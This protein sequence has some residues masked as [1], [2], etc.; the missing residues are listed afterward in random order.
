M[1]RPHSNSRSSSRKVL[2]GNSLNTNT[3][4]NNTPNCSKKLLTILKDYKKSIALYVLDEIKT[5]NLYPLEINLNSTYHNVLKGYLSILRDSTIYI[6]DTNIIDK[7]I[8]DL[9]QANKLNSIT[10][11]FS[12][13]AHSRV[14]SQ[15][16]KTL[17]RSR[18]V[19]S[20]RSRSLKTKQY[21]NT[22]KE[23]IM[24][25]LNKILCT[26]SMIF[27]YLSKDMINDVVLNIIQYNNIIKDTKDTITADTL[28]KRE[29]L[30]DDQ[31]YILR[32]YKLKYE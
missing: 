31:K 20:S 6:V 32:F 26:Q 14:R 27:K 29:A 21:T 24:R 30:L 2:S 25:K 9:P 28:A 19:S 4:T 5:K 18:N 8:S 13:S 17:S 23:N 3:S 7:I 10:K 15:Q 12:K 1:S 16:L 22:D 11:F